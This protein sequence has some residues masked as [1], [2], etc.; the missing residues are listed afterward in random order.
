MN[1]PSSTEGPGAGQTGSQRHLFLMPEDIA[2]FNT[3]AMAPVLQGVHRAGE[4]ALERAASPWAISSEDWFVDVERLRE[5]FGALLGVGDEAVAFVPSSSYGLAT[6]A[7]NLGAGPGDQVVVLAEEFPSNFYTWHRFCERT[8]AELVVVQR[9]ESLGWTGSVL[10]AIGDATRVVAVPHVHWTNGA[11]V[12]LVAVSARAK[13]A[14]AALVIDASQS[15]GALPLD[16]AGVDP[17]YVVA[18]GYKWLLGPMGFS[19]LYVAE[20]HRDGEPLEENWINRS[21]SEDFAALVDYA[22]AY[23]DGARRFDFGERSS[24]TLVPMATAAI[25]QLNEWGVDRVA[26]ELR[27][28]T[29][30]VCR[31]A[32]GLGLT[33]PAPDERGPHMIGIEV[34][35]ETAL[36][37]GEQLSKR[38]VIASV[39][40]NSLRLAPH[41]HVTTEDI[42]RLMEGVAAAL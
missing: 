16:L 28:V 3:A 41:L 13:A 19:Y 18:V 26:S 15:L 10:A 36:R 42:D 5:S 35:Q 27:A 33:V 20:R 38:G 31:R 24:F 14:G 6:A 23:R 25:E 11:L 1:A 32:E 39:R 21:S 30:E 29:D 9:E 2:Y 40:G 37:L 22:D 12:D 17:D 4:R 7:R 8:A 34:P